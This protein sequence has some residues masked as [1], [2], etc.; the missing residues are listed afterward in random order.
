MSRFFFD[1]NCTVFDNSQVSSLEIR[2]LKYVSL[3]TAIFKLVNRDNYGL[4]NLFFYRRYLY[5][6]LQSNA[7]HF[8]RQCH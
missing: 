2:E 4:R 8:G 5:M 1:S 6:H 3:T 7:K